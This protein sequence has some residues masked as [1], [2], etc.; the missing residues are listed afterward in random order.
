MSDDNH[1]GECA[2][3]GQAI[4]WEGLEGDPRPVADV[5]EECGECF[6]PDCIEWKASGE[7]G[8][9]CI[10]CYA[11]TGRNLRGDGLPVPA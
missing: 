11:E 5:C 7:A 1:Q 6:C 2:R 10:P 9:I 8:C 3:C 4:A